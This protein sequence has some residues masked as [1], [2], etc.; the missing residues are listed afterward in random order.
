MNVVHRRPNVAVAEQFLYRADVVPVG[1]QVCPKRVPEC[2]GR[3]AY[4][5]IAPP[6]C[7]ANCRGRH[8]ACVI[9]PLNRRDVK[10]MFA[11]GGDR[12]G[13]W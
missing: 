13:Q 10:V 2:M 5:D 9:A 7:A 11:A 12:A 1:Q 8:A 4:R 6:R 3:H